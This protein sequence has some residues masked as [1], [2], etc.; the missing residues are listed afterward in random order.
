MSVTVKIPKD[1]LV[2]TYDMT[3]PKQIAAKLKK[4]GEINEAR[5]ERMMEY[6]YNPVVPV[7]DALQEK[8]NNPEIYAKTVRTDPQQMQE[9]I[10]MAKMYARAS[11]INR[12]DAGYQAERENFMRDYGTN[13]AKLGLTN[14]IV[15][16]FNDFADINYSETAFDKDYLGASA[17][18]DFMKATKKKFENEL[19]VKEIIP[20]EL[21]SQNLGDY[22]LAFTM[23]NKKY[24]DQRVGMA[25]VVKAQTQVENIDK[26]LGEIEQM[27]ND[28]ERTLQDIRDRVRGIIE[29]K[30]EQPL[31]EESV[32][33]M[34][35]LEKKN[36]RERNANQK[37]V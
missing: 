13:I 29:F 21:E 31:T 22:D 35:L 1:I 33:D 8:M 4:L 6:R 5:R 17:S 14:K 24:K 12:D 18:A 7:R 34:A 19:I 9:L 28:D 30:K 10:R 36:I 16:I 32:Q 20:D 23:M 2:E 3:T 26:K 37:S 27:I 15:Q 11:R 25:N